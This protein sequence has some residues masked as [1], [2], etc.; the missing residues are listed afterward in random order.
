MDQ[1]KTAACASLTQA[2]PTPIADAAGRVVS[3]PSDKIA[4]IYDQAVLRTFELKI[5][6]KDLAILDAN[7]SAEQYVPGKLV[8]DGKE[9]G[10]VGIRYKGSVGAWVFCVAESTPENP[11]KIGGAKTC[12]KLSMKISFNEYDSKGRFFGVKKLMFHS[13][14]NDDSLMKERLGYWLYRQMG[15][16]A[17]RA[18][19]ARLLINGKYQGVFLNIEDVDG[20]FAMSHFGD[21]DGNL[22]K[23]IWPTSIEGFSQPLTAERFRSG[24]QTN[25]DK[26]P[27][28]D[29]ALAFSRDVM[30]SSGDAR[31]RAI[32]DGMSIANT[33][34][35]IAVDRTI[36]A[37]DG[38]AHI[39]CVDGAC[40]NHNFFLY[41]EKKSPRFWLIPWDLDTSFIVGGQLASTTDE[42]L[43][44]MTEWNDHSAACQI[45]P[46][47]VQYATKQFPAA[48]DPLWNGLGCYFDG[49]YQAALRELL[50]GPFSER[51]VEEKL[52]AWSAQITAAVSEANA[53]DSRQ[54]T[55]QAWADAL[56]DLRARVQYLRAQA[57]ASLRR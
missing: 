27:T 41:E 16:P 9:Y 57:Q 35:F 6:E 52:A 2:L 24:L 49:D 30:Q 12:P 3:E 50:A 28:F 54:L 29:Q 7:P 5:D 33:A 47:S 1:P 20:T 13:M 32:L 22:Y 51:V 15:V 55:P 45:G 53:T 40:L 4:D 48:C 8:Y 26:M 18:V 36:R 10:P 23:E 42:F 19:H 44:V 38:P 21:G 34:R 14:N 39:W 43:R 25:K 17:S 11:T 46:G 37:D 56:T 31:A